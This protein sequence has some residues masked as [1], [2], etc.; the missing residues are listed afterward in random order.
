MRPIFAAFAVSLL[1]IP[2]AALAGSAGIITF[3]ISAHVDSFCRISAPQDAPINIVNGQAEI[4]AISEICNTPSGYDVTAKFSNLDGGTL[5][6][7]GQGYAIDTTGLSVRHSNQARVQT[8][9]WQLADAE[10]I[11]PNAPVFMQVTITPI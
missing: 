4:G 9:N 5:N 2:S 6:V 7:A 3:Q 11:Q 1:T 10:L 8:V